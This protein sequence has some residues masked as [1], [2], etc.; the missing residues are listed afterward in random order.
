MSEFRSVF[1]DHLAGYVRLRRR[2]GFRFSR[3]EEVLRRFDRFVHSRSYRGLLT[4]DLARG[5]ALS[6]QDTAT[7]EPTRRYMAVRGF[8]E[9]LATFEP[10]TPRLDPKAVYRRQLRRPPYVFTDGELLRLLHCASRYSRHHRVLSLAVHAM[11]GLAASSGLRLREVLGLDLQDV[12]L[13]KGVLVVRQSK[14]HKDRLVPVHATTLDVL[15]A[16]AAVR[17]D[18]RCRSDE[19]AFF[20]S[21]RGRRF[22]Q[23]NVDVI[24]HRLVRR[25]D[26]HP[27]KGAPPTFY[28]LRHTFA[29]RR[30][31]AW[32][33]SGANVQALLPALATYMGHV[34]YTSTAYYLTGTPELMAAAG[35]RLAVATGEG[36]HGKDT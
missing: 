7:N 12:D 10:R 17:A 24:F 21:T 19:A 35:D 33:Q 34:E 9:Y 28:S 16:Y 5:F 4:E 8:S 31:I 27:P 3:Q 11:V 30:L 22:K 32:H 36:L 23:S 29:V 13:D 20:L 6:V 14:F 2:L 26:L 18:I 1:A 25:I 15:R